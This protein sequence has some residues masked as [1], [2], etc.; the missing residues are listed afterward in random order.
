M[1]QVRLVEITPEE[2]Q[3]LMQQAIRNEVPHL[4]AKEVTRALATPPEDRLVPRKE[5]MNLLGIRSRDT[6]I[7]LEKGGDLTPTHIGNRIHYSLANL[8]E[9]KQRRA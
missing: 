3:E 7:K 8:R 9:F 1:Q 5:A 2:L 4:V 6:M